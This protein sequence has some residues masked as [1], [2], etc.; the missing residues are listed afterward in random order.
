MQETSEDE[1]AMH[2]YE[3]MQSEENQE[4]HLQEDSEEKEEMSPEGS[5]LQMQEEDQGQENMHK[6]DSLQFLQKGLED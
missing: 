5:Y 6:R 1:G 2:E 3:V 4:D